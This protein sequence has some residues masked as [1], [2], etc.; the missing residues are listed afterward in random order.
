MTK[1]SQTT[2]GL[3]LLVSTAMLLALRGVPNP[4]PVFVSTEPAPIPS[5]PTPLP[6]AAPLF[7]ADPAQAL[8]SLPTNS[9]DRLRAEVDSACRVPVLLALDGRERPDP[10]RDP[11]LAELKRRCAALPV[12]SMY[13]PMED[14]RAPLNERSADPLAAL[15]ALRDART[16]DALL[17][18]WLD[19]YASRVLPQAEIFADGR[20]LLPAEAEYLMRAVNDV[21]ECERLNACGP[22]SLITLRVCALNGCEPG[23]DLRMAYHEALS[24]R[25]FEALLA[26]HR[27][28]LTVNPL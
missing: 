6:D 1:C 13:V 22:H 4:P 15:A 25:D 5:A 21:R 7:A 17:S 26:I 24:P 8:A 3:A 27:W 11:A 14:T 2:L 20:R 10:R 16:P 28:L 12:P 18:A 9:Q 23:S 19:A